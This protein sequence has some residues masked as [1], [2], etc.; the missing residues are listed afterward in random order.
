METRQLAYFVLA[1][2]VPDQAEAASLAGITQSTLSESL[3]GLEAETGL[4]LFGRGSRGRHPTE[5]ARWLCQIAEHMLQLVEAADAINDATTFQRIDIL[6]PLHLMLG[7]LYRAANL[8]ARQLRAE[9]AV[10]ARVHFHSPLQPAP[11]SN[12]L[13]VS[14]D[15]SDGNEHDP[16]NFLFDDDWV[17]VCPAELSGG[18]PVALDADMLRT[19]PVLIPPM[20]ATLEQQARRYCSHLGLPEPAMVEEDLGI[21]SRLSR[22]AR[23]F[24]LLAPRTLVSGGLQR[25]ALVALPLATPLRSSVVADI[26]KAGQVGPAYVAALQRILA[27]PPTAPRYDPALSLRQL[28]YFLAAA[29]AGSISA[30]ARKLNVVQPALSGQLHKLETVLGGAVFDRRNRGIDV[31]PFG[32]RLLDLTREIV[33]GHDRI[34]RESRAI[35]AAE[36]RHIS[37]GIDPLAGRASAIAEAIA[38][39]LEIYPGARV[40]FVERTPPELSHLLESGEIS[41]VIA[42][43]FG[44]NAPRIPLARPQEIGLVFDRASTLSAASPGEAL[45]M[46]GGLAIVMPPEDHPVRRAVEQAAR[47]AGVTLNIVA[48]TASVAMVAHFLTR[49]GGAGV[50]SRAIMDDAAA[51]GLMFVPLGEDAPRTQLSVL[52]SADR[53]LRDSERTLVRLLQKALLDGRSD[54]DSGQ[55]AAHPHQTAVR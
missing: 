19:L 8:A 32:R 35:S 44:R 2:H 14:L 42:E 52:F 25:S 47:S 1:C 31:T 11:A 39:W 55:D 10:L 22:Q 13:H 37:I 40:T 4:Q 43:T 33:G 36:R 16:G 46:L 7:R 20:M 6:S 27:H 5:A 34:A 15:Y 49:T 54:D 48:E 41:F 50:A 24:A 12:G 26:S 38:Q 9:R 18:E 51:S 29:D 53:G 23:L 3:S 28:R 30:A 45:A 21:F 17:A